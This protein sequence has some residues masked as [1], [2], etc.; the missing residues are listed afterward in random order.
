M[1]W[2]IKFFRLRKI[3]PITS[4]P[5]GGGGGGGGPYLLLNDGVSKLL[6]NDG[7]NHLLL[8]N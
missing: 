8:N 4:I 2:L 6:L 1:A 5:S 3:F 7:T